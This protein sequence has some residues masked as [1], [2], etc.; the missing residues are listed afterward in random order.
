MRL[1]CT[2]L[3]LLVALLPLVDTH[4]A[5]RQ[6]VFHSEANGYSVA[7]PEGWKQATDG[8]VEEM[9]NRS[10][11]PIETV[12]VIDWGD[13]GLR[14]P[15][16]MIQFIKYSD[17]F[18]KKRFTQNDIAF[19]LNNFAGVDTDNSIKTPP[20]QVAIHVGVKPPCDG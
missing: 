10:I 7:I 4:S 20:S 6:R 5:E 8:S 12:L 13:S 18:G 11:Y 3:V 17:Y 19:I 2:L 9:S 15:Y 14:C 16:L 1:K